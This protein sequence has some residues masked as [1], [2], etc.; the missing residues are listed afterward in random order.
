MTTTT[1][2]FDTAET[3]AALPREKP[4]VVTPAK[5]ERAKPMNIEQVIEKFVR[6]EVS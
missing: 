6:G 1:S 4:R 5:K 2:I 3:V